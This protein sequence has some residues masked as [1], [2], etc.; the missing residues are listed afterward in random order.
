MSRMSKARSRKTKQDVTSSSDTSEDYSAMIEALRQELHAKQDAL[1][2]KVSTFTKTQ[3]E[4]ASQLFATFS[5]ALQ[6]HCN[7]MEAE[8]RKTRLFTDS[9]FK[10]KSEQYD[11]SL[12]VITDEGTSALRKVLQASEDL[13]NTM[14]YR[15]EDFTMQLDTRVTKDYVEIIGK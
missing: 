11:K 7:E 2:Q 6:M 15:L 4:S 14:K 5:E 1:E 10:N 3:E 13:E 8:A 9:R 12:K